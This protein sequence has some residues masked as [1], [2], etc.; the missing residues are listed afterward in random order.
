MKKI[1][2][3]PLLFMMLFFLPG[4]AEEYRIACK[5][6]APEMKNVLLCDGEKFY[7]VRPDGSCDFTFTTDCEPFVYI[8]HPDYLRLTGKRSFALVPGENRIAFTLEKCQSVPGKFTFIQGS[9]I[10]YDFLKKSEELANDMTEIRDI[11]KEHGCEFI[12]FPG[13]LTEFGEPAQLEKLRKAIELGGVSCYPIWGG[14]DGLKS[15]PKMGNYAECFGAPYYS[16][17]FGGIHFIAPL[18]EYRLLPP[19][20]QKRQFNWIDADLKLLPPETPVMVLTHDPPCIAEYIEKRVSENNLRLLGYLGAHYHYDNLFRS[21]GIL[22]FYNAPLRS[23]DAGTFT[24]KLRLVECSAKD[25][26]ISTRSR[27]LNQRRRVHMILCGKQHLVALVYDTVYDPK[28]VSCVDENGRRTDM[29]RVGEFVW[30][31]ELSENGSYTG[32]PLKIEVD[33][34]P[35]SWSKQIVPGH[36]PELLWCHPTG[37]SFFRYP[38]V[39]VHGERLFLGL[40]ADNLDGVSGGVLCLDR[41]TG[42]QLW[43]TLS[44]ANISAGVASDGTSVFALT[45]DGELVTLDARN[46]KTLRSRKLEIPGIRESPASWRQAQTPLCLAGGKLL[47]HYFCNGGGYLH[48]FDPA[49]GKK[50]WENPMFLGSGNTAHGF[51]VRNGRVYFSGTDC[52]GVLNLNDGSEL[53]RTKENI[54]SSA[55][56]PLVTDDAVYYYL[57]ASLRKVNPATGE[58]LWKTGV[59]GSINSIGGITAAGDKLVAFSTNAIITVDEKT[60]KLLNR[61]NLQPLPASSGVKF[62]FLAN[63]SAPVT[64]NGKVIAAGDDGSVYRIDPAT[65]VPTAILFTGSAFKGAPAVD[66]D[67]V[68]L[69]GFEGNVYA[70]QI[71]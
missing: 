45:N 29:R 44:G 24:K 10:Q 48:C 28:R 52:Y 60:G 33:A 47:V 53:W 38:V 43:R 7:P 67:M 58:I 1:P 70:M 17:N 54:K 21:N 12:T 61:V 2:L 59:P 9:D 26:I 65:A 40:S 11:M 46:G 41:M 35:Q 62:Q 23:H 57:R 71:K 37:N 30:T 56:A 25:G 13:D 6:T 42:K 19:A 4:L 32:K 49:T 16:W 14:H 51:S 66:R 69:V 50:I 15:K 31:A 27:C 39:A 22:S 64:V 34:G 8:L 55:A 3:I 5:V 63:T 18:S 36:A 20:E 68:Y